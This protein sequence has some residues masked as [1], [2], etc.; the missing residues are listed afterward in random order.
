MFERHD[1][2]RFEIIAVSFGPEDGSAMRTRLVKAFD[3]FHDARQQSDR[4]VAGLLR[5]WEIDIAVD[6]GGYTSGARPWVLAH[7]PAPVQ[8][9]YM[10]Y[11][12]TSGSGFID[13]IVADAS[14]VPADQQAF[15]S[16][17]LA[18]LP[19]TL[20]VTDRKRALAAAPARSD[21]GLPE[22]ALV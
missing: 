17:K 2:D 7:R 16:E 13:Y 22:D 9:K 11:P 8:A 10:G 1:R 3:R 19:D 21:W 12:G 18:A 5:Q 20:W 14:V 6:L 15:F 4:D